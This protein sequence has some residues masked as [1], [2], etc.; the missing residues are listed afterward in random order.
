MVFPACRLPVAAYI[1][2]RMAISRNVLGD[3][4]TLA[5]NRKMLVKVSHISRRMPNISGENASD[6]GSVLNGLETNLASG[7]ERA[8]ES[9]QLLKV[10]GTSPEVPRRLPRRLLSLWNSTAI[11]RFTG[12]FPDLPGGQPVSLGSLTPSPDSQKAISEWWLP[13]GCP[14]AKIPCALLSSVCCVGISNHNVQTT[15]QTAMVRIVDT[16]R[17]EQGALWR[18]AYLQQLNSVSS[19]NKKTR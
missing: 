16:Y 5:Q 14:E 10:P 13:H 15:V 17:R 3:G 19:A 1:F 11:Q 4:V 9:P 2:G 18:D 12:S 7:W 6:K 8:G